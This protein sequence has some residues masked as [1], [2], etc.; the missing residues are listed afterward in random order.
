MIDAT[1][2]SLVIKID[3]L[4]PI[5]DENVPW[6]I[7]MNLIFSF[8]IYKIIFNNLI[9]RT[10]LITRH[11][12][13]SNLTNSVLPLTSRLTELQLTGQWVFAWRQFHHNPPH[14]EGR[15]GNGRGERR[16][17]TMA[18]QVARRIISRILVSVRRDF[19]SLPSDPWSMV[20]GS[21]N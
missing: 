4:R 19:P 16:R 20:K 6:N 18:S 5:D 2:A 1:D 15:R 21:G 10:T 14:S 7:C 12:T 9:F 8:N 3:L 11:K 17:T 13:A